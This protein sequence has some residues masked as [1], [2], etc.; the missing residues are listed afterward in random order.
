MR[1]LLCALAIAASVAWAQG[2][3][4]PPG[5]DTEGARILAF[6]EAKRPWRGGPRAEQFGIVFGQSRGRDGNIGELALLHEHQGTLSFRHPIDL[7]QYRALQF[8]VL[9]PKTP[10]HV[11]LAAYFVDEDSFWFQTWEPLTPVREKW[12]TLEV[13]L[14]PDGARIESQGHGRPWGRYVARGIREMGI[15]IFADRPTTAKVGIDNV[16]LLPADDP[17]GVKCPQAILNFETSAGKVARRSRFEISFELSRCYENPYDPNQIEV[18]G[19]F[20][21]PRGEV[22]RV[23]GFFYQAY[24][25]TLARKAER[26]IPAGAPQWKIRFAPPETG[27]YTYWV[28]VNDGEVLKTDPT[29]FESVPSDNPGCVQVCAEDQRCFEFE[30]GAFFYPVGINIP[31]TFNAKGARMLGVKVNKF[32]GTFA[33]DRFLRGMSRGKLNFAR[34]WLA[35]WSFGL[36]WS[37]AYHPSYRDLGR[38]N[39]EHAWQFDHVLE[40]A[41]Q[42]GIYVQLALT[43]FGHWRAGGQFEGDWPASPYNRNHG[44]KLRQ[45]QEFWRNDEAQ[46]TYQRMVRYVM[47]RWGYS[48]SIAAWE[49]SNEIDLTTGYPPQPKKGKPRQRTIEWYTDWHKRC[50]K[51]IRKYDQNPHLVTT[52]FANW[53]NDK[54]ILTLPEIQFSSTNH[55]NVQIIEQMRRHIFPLKDGYGKP[56]MMAE[57]GYDFKGAMPETTE[58]YLH[59]CLWSNY[60][61]PF[62]GNG[63]SWWWDF[64]ADRDLYPK[65]RPLAEFAAGEDRRRR[66]LQTTDATV[67]RKDSVVESGLA[68]LALQNDEGGYFWIYERRLLRAESDKDFVPPERKGL[69]VRMAGLKAGAYCVEFWDTRKGVPIA[70]ATVAAKGDA[71]EALIP[72]FTGDI[73]GK[74]KPAAAKGSSDEI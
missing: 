63:L 37:R 61:I 3:P 14:R 66:N 7:S 16:V 60:M 42:R 56:A 35:S 49:L 41:E 64:I 20:Q 1:T 25:R 30:N 43:T 12:C 72:A 36:E 69:T 9:M 33:Y 44:G 65:F 10:S 45:P 31:A 74:V 58:R 59:I 34:T 24:A 15:S 23:P 28:E 55:Y 5:S 38:Y 26:L 67:H 70:E 39:Q 13:D 52:N 18:W 47:A 17:S 48:T 11:H 51:T 2:I 29:T 40:E 53:Q 6:D 4:V 46:E 50:V 19:V 71:I 32:E 21:G 73:A 22:V 27:E 54:D 62:A 57:C 68:A 8:D